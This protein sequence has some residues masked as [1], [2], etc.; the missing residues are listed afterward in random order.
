M[1]RIIPKHESNGSWRSDT[2]HSPA[3]QYLNGL[4]GGGY[5]TIKFVGDILAALILLAMTLPLILLAAILVKLTSRGPV[6]YS[7]TRLGREGR[8]FVIY[9][10]RTM[11]HDCESLTGPKWS[12][13]GDD[14]VTWIGRILRSTHIDEFPQ[15]WNVLRGEMSLVGPRPERPEFAAGLDKVLPLYGNRLLVRPGIT[16][17][18]Q[19]QLPPD[20]DVAS[21]RRKLAHDLYYV[22]YMNFWLDLRLLL[23]TAFAVLFVPAGLTLFLLA[24]PGGNH[25][26]KAYEL[27]AAE[28]KIDPELEMA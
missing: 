5:T 1:R 15:L 13:P 28:I 11:T 26:Q 12:V 18:A 27:H 8:L 21:V 6:I 16:G 10:I 9:K 25:V 3:P 14:R 24:L 22:R 17:L 23:A 7:Q 20:T 2:P 19:V 4:E